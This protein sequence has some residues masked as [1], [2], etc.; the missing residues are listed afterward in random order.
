MPIGN[1]RGA[2]VISEI[3]LENYKQSTKRIIEAYST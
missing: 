3:K 2:K 1:T